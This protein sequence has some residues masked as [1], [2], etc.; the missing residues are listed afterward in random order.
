MSIF[1]NG[2]SVIHPF[3]VLFY[4][5]MDYNISI[6]YGDISRK[7]SY[8]LYLSII[9]VLDRR[10]LYDGAIIKDSLGIIEPLNKS[11][12]FLQLSCSVVHKKSQCM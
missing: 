11:K 3:N 7:H 1:M 12:I 8:A 10:Y 2:T 9:H 5:M 4:L 6:Q